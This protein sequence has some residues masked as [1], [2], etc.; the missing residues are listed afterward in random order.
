[1]RVWRVE[2]PVKHIGPYNYIGFPHD[3]TP[4]GSIRHGTMAYAADR[5]VACTADDDRHKAW[6]FDGIRHPD[7]DE[8]R[9]G[10][11]SLESM[12][13]WFDPLIL[14]HL[15]D[16]GFVIAIYD[17]PDEDV[18]KGRSGTQVAFR[19]RDSTP[20]KEVKY[21]DTHSGD[22]VIDSSCAFYNG[23]KLSRA[24][25]QTTTA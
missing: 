2:D 6:G 11:E 4:E 17:V 12:E 1:M 5:M 15:T 8:F 9:A 10:F 14:E 19:L 3:Y 25:A 22:P 20:R 24:I 23:G 13:E 16:A 18:L 7:L 21:A